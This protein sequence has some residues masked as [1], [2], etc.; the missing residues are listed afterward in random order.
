MV[1]YPISSTII[2]SNPWGPND[3]RTMLATDMAAR[4]KNIR[5]VDTIAISDAFAWL[6]F[7]LDTNSW[8]YQF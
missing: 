5:W 2:L 6:S 3:E 4:T 7:S 1:T 8:H